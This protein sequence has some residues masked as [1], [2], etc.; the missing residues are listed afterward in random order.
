MRSHGVVVLLLLLS[1][2]GEQSGDASP[3]AALLREGALTVCTD[4]PFAPFEIEA[5]D[6]RHTGF[7]L[8]LLREVAADRELDLVVFDRPFDG[9]LEDLEE[10]GRCDVAAAAIT[11]TAERDERVDF[12]EPYFDADQSLLVRAGDRDRYATLASVAGER[13]GVQSGTTGRTYAA[14]HLPAGSELVELEDAQALFRSVLE[15]EIAAVLQDYPVN[16]YRATQDDRFVVTETFPT[17]EQYGFAVPAG[18]TDI[19]E[20][21]DDGLDR[22]REDGRFDEIFARYFGAPV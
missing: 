15:G 21:V 17:G 19:L 11:I 20:L 9:L 8:D 1:G 2:C 6:G 4:L 22:L 18:A 7:D 10:G 12:S 3:P 13:V 14:E 16:A 5:P